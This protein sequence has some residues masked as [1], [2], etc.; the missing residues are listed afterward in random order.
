MQARI[1]QISLNVLIGIGLLI[2][3][4]AFFIDGPGGAL[5]RLLV[6]IVVGWPLGAAARWVYGRGRSYIDAR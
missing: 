4:G 6:L 1:E 2:V 5:A 3:A